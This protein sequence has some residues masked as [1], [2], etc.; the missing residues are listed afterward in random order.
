MQQRPPGGLRRGCE[1]LR[2]APAV[3]VDDAVQLLLAGAGAAPSG[4]GGR[5][6]VVDDAACGLPCFHRFMAGGLASLYLLL[7]EV[8]AP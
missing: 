1:Q 6:Q 7:L 5:R 3:V 2:W 8:R 4:D